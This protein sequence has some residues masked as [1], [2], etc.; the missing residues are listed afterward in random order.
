MSF[1]TFAECIASR[2][3]VG[4]SY[5]TFSK[6]KVVILSFFSSLQH[7]KVPITQKLFCKHDVK[8]YL[9]LLMVLQKN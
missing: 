8:E 1:S 3:W 4:D 6:I 2:R 9:K 5:I 7:I